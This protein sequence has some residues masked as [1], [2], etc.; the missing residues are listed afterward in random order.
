MAV[1]A[2]NLNSLIQEAWE[3]AL[4]HSKISARIRNSEMIKMVNSQRSKDWMNSLGK[5]FQIRYDPK[6]DRVFWRGNPENE[7]DFDLQ[8]MLFDLA[9]CQTCT[10]PSYKK[11]HPLPFISKLHW[12]IESEFAQND[13]RE[14]VKDMSKLVMG[15]SE[16]KL[17]VASHK[18]TD[19]EWED[20][21]LKM[22]GPIAE[23]CQGRLFFCFIAHPKDWY[24]ESE[25]APS[26]HQWTDGHWERL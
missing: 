23:H 7:S 22:C 10:V 25:P 6:K 8:E 14:I 2:E 3:D 13:S 1:N 16:N 12:L 19:S 17:F 24:K 21:I 20:G 5:R 26:V 9:V 15:S 11:R 18:L 4:S